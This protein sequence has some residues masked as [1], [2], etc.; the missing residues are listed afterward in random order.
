MKGPVKLNGLLSNI[1]KNN[2]HYKNQLHFE[3][4]MSVPYKS[5]RL[6][7]FVWDRTFLER[8]VCSRGVT[9]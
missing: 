4:K 8:L 7:Q 9:S 1:N 3:I 5:S 6:R 2:F